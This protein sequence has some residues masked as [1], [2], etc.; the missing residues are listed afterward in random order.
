MRHELQQC[1]GRDESSAFIYKSTAD[2][3]VGFLGRG[4]EEDGDVHVDMVHV[5][6]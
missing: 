4:K 3:C 2:F 5:L 1:P 6:F